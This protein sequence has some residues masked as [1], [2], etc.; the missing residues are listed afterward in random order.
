MLYM[1]KKVIIA[2]SREAFRKGLNAIFTEEPNAEVFEVSTSEE[3]FSLLREDS[4]D[5]TV[6]HESLITD[7]SLFFQTNVAILTTV[8]NFRMLF[9]ARSCRVLAYLKEDV[10]GCLLRSLLHLPP[11]TFLN[12]SVVATWISEYLANHVLFAIDKTILT[13]REREVF[14]LLL[15]GN[16]N[17]VIAKQLK[18]SESTLKT[19]VKHIYEKLRMNHRL[20]HLFSYVKE[21]EEELTDYI[22]E[23]IRSREGDTPK[24]G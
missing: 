22:F 14:H 11:G 2:E 19:H 23:D 3:L 24:T 15:K 4:F 13:P 21:A 18:M 5:L 7:L 20:I 9:L 12:D 16:K 8:P 10:P 17:T 6:I 1:Q